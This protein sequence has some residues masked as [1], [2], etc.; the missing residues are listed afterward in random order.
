MQRHRACVATSL[1]VASRRALL[2]RAVEEVASYPLSD[3]RARSGVTQFPAF[4]LRAGNSQHTKYAQHSAQLV[5][6]S[7]ATEGVRLSSD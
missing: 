4:T 7:D 3:R 2:R 5:A 1:R 6:R